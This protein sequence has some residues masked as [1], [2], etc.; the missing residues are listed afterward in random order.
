MKKAA[1]RIQPFLV[2]AAQPSLLTN[3]SRLRMKKKAPEMTLQKGRC[4]SRQ[5]TGAGQQQGSRWLESEVERRI[6]EA[7]T[8][9]ASCW[10]CSR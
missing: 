5:E 10:E 4:G 3:C 9:A 2:P 8:K 7:E 6:K 1:V